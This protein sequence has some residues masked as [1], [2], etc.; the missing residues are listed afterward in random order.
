MATNKKIEFQAKNVKAFTAWLKRF[1]SIDNSL[2]LEIDEK[3]SAFVAKTYNEERSVVK[4]SKINFDDAGLLTKSGKDAKRIKV[5][6]FNIPRFIKIIDQ[7]NDAEFTLTVNYDEVVN[8]DNSVQF[9][10]KDVQLKNKTLKMSIDCTS[11]NIFKYITDELF[12][13]TI[14]AMDAT[15]EF[16]LSK[17]NIEKLNSLCGLDSD[18]KFMEFKF[19][20][21]EVLAAGKSF[22]LQI[23]EKKVPDAAINIFKDQFANIDV[24]NY[25]VQ[26]GEDR[27]IF[28]SKDSETTTVISMAVDN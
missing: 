14:A 7:F 9:A 21:G 19:V 23:E 11:L 4:M 2:L 24:E 22:Q 28:N 1:S 26:L 17:A 3:N 27:L 12:T 5:G 13:G 8:D 16:E 6:F 20:D 15:G 25:D 18:H 10:G